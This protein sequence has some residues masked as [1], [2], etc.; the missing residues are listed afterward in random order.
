MGSLLPLFGIQPMC[1]CDE[2][3]PKP[4]TPQ[5]PCCGDHV[6]KNLVRVCCVYV[7]HYK[8]AEFMGFFVMCASSLKAS[9]DYK[10]SC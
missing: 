7:N 5:S 9:E 2:K 3:D 8:L 6:F 10:M 1:E 4:E